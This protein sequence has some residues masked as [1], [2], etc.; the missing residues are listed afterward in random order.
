MD[1][2]SL[3]VIREFINEYHINSLPT[4]TTEQICKEFI[5]PLTSESKESYCKTM[6]HK[7]PYGIGK[8]TIF[9]SHA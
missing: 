5:I 3:R 9:I 6:K 4:Y 8:A 2:L 1:G 7:H